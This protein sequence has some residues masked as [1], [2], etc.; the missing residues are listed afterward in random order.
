MLNP[1]QQMPNVMQ[2]PPSRAPQ[3]VVPV[4]PSVEQKPSNNNPPYNTNLPVKNTF[5]KLLGNENVN[6]NVTTK[7]D[8]YMP[9]YLRRE[10]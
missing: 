8:V 9:Q 3:N 2:Y 6:Q 1:H 10:K 5:Q 7:T 4:F